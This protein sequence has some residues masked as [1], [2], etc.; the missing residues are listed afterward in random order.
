MRLARAR[1]I[2]RLR[3]GLP[4]TQTRLAPRRRGPTCRTRRSTFL[5]A[6]RPPYV[7]QC[8]RG[9]LAAGQWP[10]ARVPSHSAAGV[11]GPGPGGL[12]PRAQV[13]RAPTRLPGGT[14]RPPSSFLFGG[15]HLPPSFRLPFPCSFLFH[16]FL[17]LSIQPHH[18]PSS[19]ILL[20]GFSGRPCLLN[21][22]P[23]ERVQHPGRGRVP[24]RIETKT[25][26]VSEG[27]YEIKRR[28][29]GPGQRGNSKL[30][31]PKEH[32]IPCAALGGLLKS[33]REGKHRAIEVT[34]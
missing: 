27:V 2:L 25:V 7:A 8:P 4:G 10:S 17:F 1:R 22:K 21:S 32:V 20:P 31:T 30:G 23:A 5:K 28:T 16:P 33:R 9:L 18:L 29:G 26:E 12:Q 34:H 19:L 3:R 14:C 11:R 15:F 6:A 13:T 24:R